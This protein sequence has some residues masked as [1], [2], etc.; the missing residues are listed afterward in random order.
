MGASP[1]RTVHWRGLPAAAPLVLV[2]RLDFPPTRPAP[3]ADLRP[4]GAASCCGVVDGGLGARG[5]NRSLTIPPR[6]PSSV[7]MSDFHCCFVDGTGIR[8]ATGPQCLGAQPDD[9]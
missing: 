4:G 7:G 6:H 1:V 3:L 8:G 2:E 9:G 5:T